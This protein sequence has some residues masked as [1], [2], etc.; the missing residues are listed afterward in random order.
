[1]L[2]VSLAFSALSR[3]RGRGYI[4][5]RR[6]PVNPLGIKIVPELSISRIL[7]PE[8][9]GMAIIHLVSGSLR[10]SS[11][12]PKGVGRVILNPRRDRLSI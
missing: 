9:I 12:L 10:K 6:R 7:F 1:M 2:L 3:A 4:T 5:C 8:K 11:G